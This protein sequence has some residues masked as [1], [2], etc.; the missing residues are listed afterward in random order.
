MFLPSSNRSPDRPVTLT[1]FPDYR[2]SNPV[3]ALVYDRLAP[4]IAAL[5]GGIEAALATLSQRPGPRPVFHLHWEDAVLRPEGAKAEAFLNALNHFCASGGRLI[6]TVHN[7]I[8]HDAAL[9]PHLADL[10]AGLFE[11]AVVIHLHS[12]P[13]LAAARAAWPLPVAKLRVIAHPSY[14][15]AYPEVDRQRARAELGVEGAGM[16][17][18][19]PGRQAAYKQPEVLLHAFRAVAGPQDRLILAGHL[20]AGMRMPGSD[21]P[22]ILTRPG[23]ASA[24]DLAQLHAAADLVVLPYTHSLTSGSAI[25][26]ASLAR[27]V[28]GPDS[29]GLRDAVEAGRGG[30]LYD[31][32]LPDALPQALAAALAEGPA[33]WEARGRVARMAQTSR[34]PAIVAA[35]WRDLILGLA[36]A[37]HGARP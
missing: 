34:D 4:V 20:A 22:R 36:T 28:L 35:T 23:F 14:D 2:A 5:P 1:F 18:L 13:A 3:Q 30:V 19:L 12:L 37:P 33:V 6:W 32:E 15:G 21:D 24:R 26:A 27:G 11:L 29:A 8:S 31:S 16:A 10:R 17:L 25:L 7:L 9:E